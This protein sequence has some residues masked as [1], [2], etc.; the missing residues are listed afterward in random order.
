M[1]IAGRHVVRELM[2]DP[3]LDP[4]THRLALRGLA[5]INRVTGSA[6]VLWRSIRQIAAADRRPL[7][8]LDL[9]CGGGDVT[10]A[11]RKLAE[12][13][14]TMV[15]VDGCDISA[16]AVEHAH[17]QAER[18]RVDLT[19]FRLDALREAIP[20]GYDVVTSG[21][22]F[23]HLATDDA[24]ALLR[25]LSA[26]A[27]HILVSDLERSRMGYWAA[28]TGARLLSRSSVVHHDGPASVLA[29]FSKQEFERLAAAA[30]LR[31]ARVTRWWPFRLLLEWS[32][33]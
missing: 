25:K 26:S 16:T 28:W 22:F 8:V 30:G 11:I 29:A 12:R 6:A 15:R 21:L 23:H 20:A 10:I 5:N 27:S 7:R 2:D 24:Q 33:A 14:G 31:G 3:M 19:F 18:E 4:A 17:Q 13:D 9:A 32:R 1:M